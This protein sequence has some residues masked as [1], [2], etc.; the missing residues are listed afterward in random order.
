MQHAG[1]N[2]GHN[3][4]TDKYIYIYI[5]MHTHSKIK[6]FKAWELRLFRKAFETCFLK[7]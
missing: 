3:A 4:I 6:Q 5:Y 1:V 7:I 2:G